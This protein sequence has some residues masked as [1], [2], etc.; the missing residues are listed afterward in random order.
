MK[1][2]VAVGFTAQVPVYCFELLPSEDLFAPL[3]I[4]LIRL[5]NLSVLALFFRG[6]ASF[7][8]WKLMTLTDYAESLPLLVGRVLFCSVPVKIFLPSTL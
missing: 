7:K 2:A 4:L 1:S 3:A 5:G 8:S 6:E